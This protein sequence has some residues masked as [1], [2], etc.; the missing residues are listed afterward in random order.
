M[1]SNAIQNRILLYCRL[2]NAHY[3]MSH[4]THRSLFVNLGRNFLPAP[5]YFK[6]A[7]LSGIMVTKLQRS[8]A[9]LLYHYRI[10]F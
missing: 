3:I 5:P 4:I 8:H 9:Q 1:N 10:N 6:V 7:K 2:P